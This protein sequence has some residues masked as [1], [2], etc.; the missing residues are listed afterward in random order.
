LEGNGELGREG[1]EV[2]IDDSGRRKGAGEKGMTY[3]GKKKKEKGG[4]SLEM[5]NAHMNKSRV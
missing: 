1:G 4:K 3:S 5:A 2:E